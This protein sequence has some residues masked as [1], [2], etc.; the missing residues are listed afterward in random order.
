MQLVKTFLAIAVLTALIICPSARP[1]TA[2]QHGL[3]DLESGFHDVD[4][5]GNT[6]VFTYGVI[7]VPAHPTVDVGLIE[8]AG[9][10]HGAVCKQGRCEFIN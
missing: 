8:V 10:V 5:S 7:D 6:C 2:V 9:R 1:N 4:C 3:A